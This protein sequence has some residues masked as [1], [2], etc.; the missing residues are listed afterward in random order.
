MRLL[1]IFSICL[2]LATATTAVGQ[3]QATPPHRVQAKFNAKYPEIAEKA[4]WQKNDQGY[5]A[6]FQENKREVISDFGPDG[7]WLQSRTQLREGDL[8]PPTRMYISDTYPKDYEF[9]S[10]YRIE[11]A[12]GSRYEIDLRSEQQNYRLDFDKQ[13]GFVGQDPP[14]E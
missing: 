3:S 4:L 12:K 2:F 9:I 8:P 1:A 7:K 11:N 10:G 5:Q 13:G 6:R 14:I